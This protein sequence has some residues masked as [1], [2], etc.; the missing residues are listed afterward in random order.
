MVP[1]LGTIGVQALAIAALAIAMLL[2]PDITA[3]ANPALR[4]A[5]LTYLAVHALV[6][7]LMALHAVLRW[8]GG[9]VSAVR[10][11]DLRLAVLWN[12]YAAVAALIGLGFVFALAMGGQ[13]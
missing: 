3:H 9:F 13:A 1:L 11:T 4:F 10:A 12:D 5:L 7:G 8:R 6:G 2:L